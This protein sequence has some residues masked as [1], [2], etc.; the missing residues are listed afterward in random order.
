MSQ[1]VGSHKCWRGFIQGAWRRQ[2]CSCHCALLLVQF[3]H[4]PLEL[5]EVERDLDVM[6]VAGSPD[7]LWKCTGKVCDEERPSPIE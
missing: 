5:R 6:S 7:G 4:S 2:R 1:L 3:L